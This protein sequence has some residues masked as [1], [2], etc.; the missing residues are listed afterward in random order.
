MCRGKYRLNI[1]TLI[2]SSH[3]YNFLDC[4][5]KTYIL[6]QTKLWE[7]RLKT[8]Y[9]IKITKRTVPNLHSHYWCGA[10]GQQNC[11]ICTEY[12]KDSMP[13]HQ[14][15]S[16]RKE[17]SSQK[18]QTTRRPNKKRTFQKSLKITYALS[19]YIVRISPIAY[20]T[21]PNFPV[22]FRSFPTS[23]V[24]TLIWASCIFA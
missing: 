8:N 6:D 16:A 20:C 12:L 3:W 5:S 4:F 7:C 24:F 1:F 21:C 15:I 11:A 9:D 17:P 14:N 22:Y 18:H 13:G 2:F 10:S 19:L 23:S